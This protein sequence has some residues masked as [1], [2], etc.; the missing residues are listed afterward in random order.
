AAAGCGAPQSPRDFRR[1]RDPRTGCGEPDLRPLTHCVVV[2]VGNAVETAL[3]LQRVEEAKGSALGKAE[4]GRHVPE[5]ERSGRATEQF[6]HVQHLRGGLDQIWICISRH[7]AKDS[8]RWVRSQNRRPA[9]SRAFS[10]GG[11]ASGSTT[12]TL[13]SG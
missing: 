5:C 2:A 11:C 3:L 13:R 8:N 10:D 1:E 4:L 9:S 6:E 7:L 12:H